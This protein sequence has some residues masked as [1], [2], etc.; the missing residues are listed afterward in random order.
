ML[1]L[2]KLKSS[3]ALLL[4]LCV[5]LSSCDPVT[6]HRIYNDTELTYIALPKPDDSAY[7][8]MPGSYLDLGKTIGEFDQKNIKYNTLIIMNSQHDTVFRF[9]SRDELAYYLYRELK[10]NFMFG[11]KDDLPLS[12]LLGYQNNK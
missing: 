10:G 2:K 11:Y 3:T 7:Y 6:S 4:I 12:K 5:L 1:N 8:L 9:E